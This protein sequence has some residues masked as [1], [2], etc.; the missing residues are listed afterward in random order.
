[1]PA[2]VTLN[3]SLS[4]GEYNMT[5][6]SESLESNITAEA[7]MIIPREKGKASIMLQCGESGLWINS[8]QNHSISKLKK[9]IINTTQ[10]LWIFFAS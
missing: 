5:I 6:T 10:F 4:V 2:R 1:M 9:S 8:H 7:S 3:T